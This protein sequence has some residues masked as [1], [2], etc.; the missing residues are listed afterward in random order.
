MRSG[1]DA[2]DYVIIPPDTRSKVSN[3]SSQQQEMMPQMQ[4]QMS[5]AFSDSSRNRY[6]KEFQEEIDRLKLENYHLK[7]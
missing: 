1:P 7:D 3:R 4:M 6:M 5:S 2:E